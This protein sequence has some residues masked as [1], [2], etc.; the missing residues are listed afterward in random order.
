[1]FLGQKSSAILSIPHA[2][3]LQYITV[4]LTIVAADNNDGI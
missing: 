3:S 2:N 1:M 4:L